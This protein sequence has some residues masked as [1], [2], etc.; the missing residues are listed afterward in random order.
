MGLLLRLSFFLARSFGDQ[1]SRLWAPAQLI[2]KPL[3][4]VTA[5][6]QWGQVT[7]AAAA[8]SLSPQRA[9]M[10]EVHVTISAVSRHIWNC[11][12]PPLIA[13]LFSE[14]KCPYPQL[15]VAVPSLWPVPKST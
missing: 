10:L 2:P 8:D 15:S 9:D 13:S 4:Q 6:V 5:A 14:E 3:G 12:G 1:G 11:S 7:A